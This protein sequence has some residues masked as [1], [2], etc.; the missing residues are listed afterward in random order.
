MGLLSNA[1]LEGLASIRLNTHRILGK[2]SP[3][4]DAP[5][6]THRAL[7]TEPEDAEEYLETLIAE[8]LQTILEEANVGAAASLETIRSW[9]RDKTRHGNS[10]VLRW[11]KN[12]Q[13]N[14]K[15]LGE[16]DICNL[17]NVG[18]ERWQ[19]QGAPKAQSR[20]MLLTN[21]FHAKHTAPECLDE[22]F[23]YVTTVRSHYG[24]RIPRL[25]LGTVLKNEKSGL[26]WVCIQP[27]CDC[28]RITGA[29]S[30]PFLPLTEIIDKNKPFNCVLR[31]SDQ[32][33]RL[34]LS[35][36][37]WD[38]RLITFKTRAKDRGR[39]VARLKGNVYYFTSHGRTEYRWLGELKPE[40][41]LRLA[42][43]FGES[44]SRVGLNE[45]EWLRRLAGE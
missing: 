20:M 35:K 33:V 29:R 23:A 21:M 7:L 14:D 6:L 22:R 17:L 27:R 43:Q 4:L 41:A 1:A 36:K 40:H 42:H 24:Q 39:I 26:C 3:E 30:F 19:C 44:L 38:M 11:M 16:Q 45:S 18:N 32:Y 31:Q 5:Y 10:F 13:P 2:F 9:L 28:V 15:I 8:E 37:S 12:D 25:T 34:R